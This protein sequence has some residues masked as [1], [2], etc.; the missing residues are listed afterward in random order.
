[1]SSLVRVER[2]V[3]KK[4]NLVPRSTCSSEIGRIGRP[5]Q[6]SN[7]EKS[8]NCTATN[9]FLVATLPKRT[10]DGPVKRDTLSFNVE[11]REKPKLHSN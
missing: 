3:D 6:P 10:P 11:R 2:S 4:R 9:V 8:E 5:Y 7:V 1:M